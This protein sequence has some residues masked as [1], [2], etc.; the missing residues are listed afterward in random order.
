LQRWITLRLRGRLIQ[1]TRTLKEAMVDIDEYDEKISFREALEKCFI[2]LCK[3]LDIQVPMW[4]KKNT[5]EFAAFGRT[6]FI[7]E[8][9]IEKV[10]FQRFEIRYFK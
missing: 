6:S 9:F 3:E 10:N 4:L 8:Q 1:G 5:T 2:S 7:D